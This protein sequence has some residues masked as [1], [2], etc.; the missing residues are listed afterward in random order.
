MKL[1]LIPLSVLITLSMLSMIGLGAGGELGQIGFGQSITGPDAILYT[2]TAHQTVY[3]N[4]TAIGEEGR[5]SDVDGVSGIAFWYNTSYGTPF[6]L[7]TDSACTI[8]AKII[9][10]SAPLGGGAWTWEG[11]MT[12]SLGLI[13]LIVGLMIF[14]TVV[15][16][17]FLTYGQSELG[18]SAI[19]KGTAFIA[20]WGVFSLLALPLMGD[21]PL[22]I[23]YFILTVIYTLGIINS[24][25]SP[26][27][28]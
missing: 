1:I 24:V 17:R 25:G 13:A 12:S 4:G 27:N 16:A 28:E 19:F 22:N 26:S 8:P 2:S 5:I 21:V 15:G 10:T 9:D 6:E 11:S 7:Y 23:L 18:L 20:I 14:L 3:A